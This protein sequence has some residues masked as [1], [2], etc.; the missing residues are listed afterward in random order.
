MKLLHC[1]KY[2]NMEGCHTCT[3]ILLAQLEILWDNKGIIDSATSEARASP[4]LYIE[5]I[6]SS[7]EK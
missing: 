7:N 4:L 5:G 6:Q 2:A 1:V 3:Y